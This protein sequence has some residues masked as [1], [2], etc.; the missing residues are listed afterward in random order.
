MDRYVR[1]AD[2]LREFSQ[3]P[4]I[5]VVNDDQAGHLLDIYIMQ[6][7]ERNRLGTVLIEE[8]PH[9]PFLRPGK[10]DRGFRV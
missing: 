8:V 4:R 6:P 7:L 2:R 10:H 3:T 9:A 5:A 1:P